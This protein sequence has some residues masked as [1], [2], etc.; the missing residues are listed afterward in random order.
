[1]FAIYLDKALMF[2]THLSLWYSLD[3]VSNDKIHEELFFMNHTHTHTH[4]RPNN[5]FPQLK[6]T[7]FRKTTIYTKVQKTTSNEFKKFP[8]KGTDKVLIPHMEYI[9]SFT[10]KLMVVKMMKP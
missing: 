6:I 5:I 2:L 9:P 1:M 8:S 3:S 4:K 7:S 10:G